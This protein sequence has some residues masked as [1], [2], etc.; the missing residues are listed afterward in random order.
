MITITDDF[1][2]YSIDIV[3]GG[4]VFN[5]IMDRS[6]DEC[7]ERELLDECWDDSVYGR[8]VITPDGNIF[9]WLQRSEDRGTIAHEAF[10]VARHILNNVHGI[11]LIDE[12]EE[13]YARMVGTIVEKINAELV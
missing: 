8:S 3:V 4:E 6:F 10:H 7:V 5:Y 13:V 12:T 11:P 2:K 9:I 1:W